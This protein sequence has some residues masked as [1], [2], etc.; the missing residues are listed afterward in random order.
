MENAKTI[1]SFLE[2]RHQRST[3]IH[4]CCCPAFA[5][6]GK[7]GKIFATGYDSDE[8]LFSFVLDYQLILFSS[9]RSDEMDFLKFRIGFGAAM[10]FIKHRRDKSVNSCPQRAIPDFF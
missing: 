1:N 10:Q 7:H 3:D 5:T 4:A 6:L 9:E 2:R 8:R